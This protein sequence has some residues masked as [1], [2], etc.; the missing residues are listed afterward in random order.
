MSSQTEESVPLLG[1]SDDDP[2]ESNGTAEPP[3]PGQSVG[4]EPA[5]GALDSIGE[6]QPPPYDGE[7]TLTPMTSVQSQRYEKSPLPIN[8]L[9]HHLVIPVGLFAVAD[10]G[11]P[12]PPPDWTECT[13]PEGLPFPHSYGASLI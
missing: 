11:A 13:H 5:D 4:N 6:A 1:R 12:R 7:P 8:L 9:P 2:D 3:Q 10:S